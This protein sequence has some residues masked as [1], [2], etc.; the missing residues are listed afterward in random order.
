MPSTPPAP[1]YARLAEKRGDA[2]ELRNCVEATI[3]KLLAAETTAARP[4]ML[5]GKVQSGKTRAFLGIVALA[6]DRGFD[7][8]VILTKGTKALARQTLKRVRDDLSEFVADDTVQ[9]FDIMHLPQNLTNY[10]LDQKLI[11]ISKKEDDNLRLMEAFTKTYPALRE[12]RLLLVDDEADFAS[13][14][15]KKDKSSGEIEQGTIANQIDVLRRLTHGCSVLQVTATPYSLFLQPTGTDWP[16]NGYFKPKRPAFTELVPVHP[17]YVG[18]D[19]Y[20][21]DFE[22]GD[23]GYHL[24]HEVS[25]DERDALKKEDGRRLKL[26]EVLTS[27]RVQALRQAIMNFIVGGCIRRAQQS[28]ARERLEKYSFI[29]HTEQAR[30]S[31]DWQERVVTALRDEFVNLA[32]TGQELLVRLIQES[33]DD[34]AKSLEPSGRVPPDRASVT[35]S[36]QAALTSGHV[37]VTT[38][39]SDRDVEELLDDETG[40]LRL[41]TP[42]NIFIGGQI[43]D[44]GVTIGNLIGFYYGRS[45]KRMQQDTVLQHSRMYG[46]RPPADFA[47][48]R[49]YTTEHV[50]AAMRRIHDFD[51]A[52]RQAIEDGGTDSG[53]YFLRKDEGNRIVP[54]APNK[55]LLSNIVTLRASRRLLPVGFQSKAKSHIATIISSLD[56]QIESL[57]ERQDDPKLISTAD[58]VSIIREVEKSLELDEDSDWSWAAFVAAIEYLSNISPNTDEKGRLWLLARWDRS[59]ARMREGGRLSDAPDTKQQ[60]DLARQTSVTTPTLM[61]FR[62]NGEKDAGW[63]GHPFWW[64]VL[65]TPQRTPTSVFATED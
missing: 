51:S 12:K 61:L 25:F 9:I 36:V 41:R 6:F 10:E 1:F 26:G 19:Q 23:V 13:I 34:L 32:R 11:I 42:F 21:G 46:A 2:P 44:R 56:S 49:F 22:P 31:H 65:V 64:P 16:D 14:A 18:G 58:A 15:F 4:G 7:V 40:Q 54:C 5:L 8:V 17:S 37:M 28:E 55:I 29:I 57:S 45:P 39:N 60:V 59:I 33:Y 24:Y 47:V 48:T 30:A 63:G 35:N 50:Y 20:F 27:R 3:E 43:L 38:V 52:L 62:Q 53:V